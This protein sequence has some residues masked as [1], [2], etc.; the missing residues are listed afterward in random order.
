MKQLISFL[1][2]QPEI[3]FMG[4][5]LFYW[6][7]TAVVF[8]P[9]AISL[10]VLFALQLRIQNRKMGV[11]LPSIILLICAYLLLALFSE[12]REF[13]AVNTEALVLLSVGLLFL[14]SAASLSF[15]MIRKYL[16]LEIE[17]TN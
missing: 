7:S 1:K 15:L 4:V 3:L 10:M 16:L 6:V 9:I 2:K 17:A 5:I 11:L 13:P 14:G 8:N 12:F